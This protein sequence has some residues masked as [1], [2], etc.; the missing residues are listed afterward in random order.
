MA[1]SPEAIFSEVERKTG[2]H[3]FAD[4]RKA[5][6]QAV[7]NPVTLTAI[8]AQI[9][10]LLTDFNGLSLQDL[11]FEELNTEAENA[12]LVQE[13]H[14]MINDGDIL[15]SDMYLTTE[16]IWWLLHA[17]G[18]RKRVTL[19][20]SY[21]GKH[22]GRMYDMLLKQFDI[23]THFGDNE[24]SDVRMA[25]SRGINAVH[26]TA[27]ANTQSESDIRAAGAPVL[28][29][30]L[31]K[32]R[33]TN[34]YN[35]GS[36]Q[37]AL[38][39]VQLD[40]NIPFLCV[41]SHHLVTV[42][43]TMGATR[44][45]FFTRDGCLMHIITQW[46]YP[47]MA[48]SELLCSRR[49]FQ[50]ADPEF[51]Q[52]IRQQNVFTHAVL[53][54]MH[55]SGNSATNFFKQNFDRVPP[56]YIVDACADVV[57]N[58]FVFPKQRMHAGAYLETLNADV[59]G[60]LLTI[61]AAGVIRRPVEHCPHLAGA[62]HT[63]V[64][65][66]CATGFGPR[67]AE[68]LGSCLESAG[69][70]LWLSQAF[71]HEATL[72]A[73]RPDNIDLQTLTDIANSCGSDKGSS[74]GCAHQYTRIYE[75]IIGRILS[76]IPVQVSVCILELGLYKNPAGNSVPSADMFVQY[77]HNRG[78]QYYGFDIVP[79][80]Q[81]FSSA[82][83]VVT[84]L[85]GDVSQPASLAQCAG[86]SYH[87]IIDDASHASSHQQIALRELWPLVSPGG[88]YVIEDLHF[89]PFPETVMLTRQVLQTWTPTPYLSAETLASIHA[90]CATC[91]FYDSLSTSW[92]DCKNAL[93]VLQK[94]AANVTEQT[95]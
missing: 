23:K 9:Q 91:T 95:L 22:T 56:L 81:R 63:A 59:K 7:G 64:A 16:Q 26:I 67:I 85:T 34:P 38:Y 15:I 37:H 65:L 76:M 10:R 70:N 21:N 89:Q 30:L 1:G 69:W 32:H 94:H 66:I 90:E 80:F 54:D 43:K 48:C 42:A 27:T 45:L 74:V 6:E 51:L 13:V 60:S 8:Y 2:I 53:V 24:H 72:R 17:A 18:F 73:I 46:L 11:M 19:Y 83:G 93:V 4:A 12:V 88:F 52:Y 41:V 3:G 49:A 82:D 47:E 75:L 31:R 14:Q 58:A 78:L 20:V 35:A 29:Q 62:M 61:N 87:L 84:I 5:A 55:A 79:E 36:M 28:A 71:R 25:K 44:L 50:M 86:R 68:E 40:T 92:S 57:P 39:N 77:F 33:L